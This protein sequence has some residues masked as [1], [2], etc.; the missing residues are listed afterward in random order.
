MTRRPRRLLERMEGDPTL[1]YRMHK[2]MS[3]VWLICMIVTP[4][5]VIFAPV[6]WLKVGVLWVSE[7]SYYANWATDNGAMSAASASTPLDVST[8]AQAEAAEAD[9][10]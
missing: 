9:D 10:A 4:P 8:F 7:I 5:I 3:R 2:I 1:Q 6:F